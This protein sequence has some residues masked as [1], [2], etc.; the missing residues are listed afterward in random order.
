MRSTCR[1]LLIVCCVL[2]TTAWS[3]A[4]D[5][6][7]DVVEHDLWMVGTL[8]QQPVANLNVVTILHPDGSR[9]STTN[10]VFELG[11]A[12]G[13]NN[14]R[15][16]VTQSGLVREDA[17][18]H[19]VAVEY[20]AEEFGSLSTASATIADGVVRGQVTRAGRV[21]PVEIALDEGVELM[22]EYGWQRRIGDLNALEPG[23]TTRVH[24][25]SLMS[26]E[27]QV[28]GSTATLIAHR[29][30]GHHVQM[31]MDLAPTMPVDTLLTDA[32][33][34]VKMRMTMGPMVFDFLPADGPAALG[35]AT[36][37]MVGMATA[38]G[39]APTPFGGNR[40]RLAPELLAGLPAD[41]F[42]QVADGMLIITDQAA[43]TDLPDPE[44][45]LKVE[46][47]LEIDDP[48]LIAW[49]M[50][51]LVDAPVSI[52]ERAEHL[53]RAVRAHFTNADLSRGEATALEAFRDRAGD[54]TEHANLLT[55]ALRI[56]GIPA[57]HDVGMVYAAA[58][59]GWGGH[60]WTAAYDQTSGRWLHLD[61]AYPGIGRGCYIRTGSAS[62]REQ[63]GPNEL[64][65]RGLGAI[66]GATI[67]VV[68]AP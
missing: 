17:N 63:G 24:S 53:R 2:S 5:V 61:A 23:F 38:V 33:L 28:L 18:G 16:R 67:E 26:G 27:L 47:Q 34:P 66:L 54:C 7:S 13:G 29:D 6:D 12:L 19:V 48:D 65:D 39:P 55:A 50:E 25:L 37:E 20:Q 52:P 15:L 41:G 10:M 56:A 8:N 1:H 58:Y 64:L 32:G 59:G 51:L 9:S 49:V 14:T 42:Q 4:A 68:P 40:Y 44:N 43:P 62:N 30:D 31:V 46:A 60:A 45:Y 36:L 21:T 35:G 22:S 11:R 57:R 3:H